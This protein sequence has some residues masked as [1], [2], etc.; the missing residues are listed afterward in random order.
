MAGWRHLFEPEETVGTLW[1]RATRKLAPETRFPDAAVHLE[2]V[3]GRLAVL[4]RGLGGGGGVELRALPAQQSMHRLGLFRRVAVESERV[5]AARFDGVILGLPEVID[6]FP[7]PALNGDLYLWFAALTAFSAPAAFDGDP[8]QADI[9]A[10]RATHR[11]IGTTLD[12]CPG[13]RGVYRRLALALLDQRPAAVGPDTERDVEAAV[14]AM[15]RTGAGEAMTDPAPRLLAAITAPDFD[16]ST[17]LAPFEYKP[18]R[19]VV[20]WPVLSPPPRSSNK[21]GSRDDDPGSGAAEAGEKRL[22][23]ERRTADQADRKDSLIVH[24]FEHILSWAEFLNINRAVDDDD[25]DNA[26]KTA[27]DAD[28]IS[29]VKNSKKAQTR[30]KFDLDLAPEDV[31]TEKLSGTSLYPEWD[32][33]RGAYHADHARVLAS[34]AA[35]APEG[36]K[37]DG[38]TRRRINAVRRRFEALRPGRATVPRQIDGDELDLEAA[39]RAAIDLKGR[40]EGSDRIWRRR[41]DTE[42]DLAVCVLVDTSRST[43]GACGSRTVLDIAR[44]ALIAFT[45][46]VSACGDHVAVQSFSSLRRDRVFVRSVKDYDESVDARVHARIAGLKPGFYTRIGAAIRHSASGLAARPNRKKLLLILTD[47]RPNDLD[48]YEGRYGVEDTRRAVMEARRQGLAVFGV[49][50]DAKARAYFPY[51]FGAN[52]FAIVAKPDKLVLALP[53]VW[54]HLVDG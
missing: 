13:L 20:L 45:E 18:F 31:D 21:P 47:G 36:L 39:V 43:E 44:E 32:Y 3:R 22:K 46:G 7:D 1:H 10:L 40:G 48:H 19:P 16:L 41:R 6:V 23:A 24:R 8:L 26:R 50:I 54:Q 35:E 28:K 4:F 29:V 27:D 14:V 2:A 49:T 33:K 12:A 38:P 30:L 11:A 42:R 9:A 53:L 25:E 15:L 34:P 52:G 17:L 5:P 37:L 51:I